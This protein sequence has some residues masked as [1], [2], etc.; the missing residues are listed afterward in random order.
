M[1]SH[2]RLDL[3]GLARPAL[4]GSAAVASLLVVAFATQTATGKNRLATAYSTITG[5]SE[6]AALEREQKSAQREHVLQVETRNLT[7]TMRNLSA[8]RDQLLARMA[9]LERNYEDV[10]TGS[11]GRLTHP[12]QSS[13]E[14]LFPI[15]PSTELA[16][17]I[18]PPQ[19]IAT[20]PVDRDGA[21]APQ[22]EL[23][24]T[25]SAR[26]DF[27]VDLGGAPTLASIRTAWNQIRRNHAS[28]LDGL[29]PVIGVRDGKGG[30]VDLRL[31]AGPIANAATAAKLCASLAA[32]NQPC[33]PATFDGQRLALR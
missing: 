9:V 3:R 4:W 30:Q 27:G 26:T 1:V 2:L 29:R 12:P 15:A 5:A 6:V 17:V 19:P 24:D 11:I 32:S 28:L 13:T 20:I 31:I 21:A 18:P 22:T 8:D 33:Q 10:V 25:T 23:A 16:P 14:Q 7:E